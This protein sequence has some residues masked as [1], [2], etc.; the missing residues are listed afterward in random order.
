M[1]DFIGVWLLV[2]V[3][4]KTKDKL[5][6]PFGDNP[7]GL[8]IYSE[9]YMSAQLGIA[10]RPA[11]DSEDFRNG[12]P[13]EIAIAFNSYIA[14]YGTYNVDEAEKIVYHKVLQ[15]LYPNWVGTKQKRYFEF[16]SKYLSLSA[17]D[18]DY[19]T[20]GS[21]TTLIWERA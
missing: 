1:K 19:A 8:L 13:D 7:E 14:Y 10:N 6:S 12:S 2:K 11:F 15:S 21:T 16:S 4:R 3:E 18:P 9:G 17:L 5:L 20:T